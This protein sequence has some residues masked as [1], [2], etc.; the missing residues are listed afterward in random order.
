MC[1][2]VTVLSLTLSTHVWEGY[3]TQFVSQS[4]ILSHNKKV[5][6][7]DGSLPKNETSIK[8]IALDNF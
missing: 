7:K 5:D 8:N 1:E 6:F 4:H 3:S 2:R